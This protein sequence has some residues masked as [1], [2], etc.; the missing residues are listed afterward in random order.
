MMMV[1]IDTRH[2]TQRKKMADRGLARPPKTADKKKKKKGQ[3]SGRVTASP[4]L[5]SRE[6][7][8]GWSQLVGKGV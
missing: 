8:P 7:P 3:V 6:G 1:V 4:R 5:D 2:L